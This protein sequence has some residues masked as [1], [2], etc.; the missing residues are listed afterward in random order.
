MELKKLQSLMQDGTQTFDEALHLLFIKKI[1]T[2]MVI[3]QV[4]KNVWW[5][6]SVNM[7]N[8]KSMSATE[9]KKLLFIFCTKFVFSQDS[10][11]N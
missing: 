2:E 10:A 6:S 8:G 5:L 7:V 1:K 11:T 3:Y 9:K 4:R